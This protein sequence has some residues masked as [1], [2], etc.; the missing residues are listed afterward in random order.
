MKREN[1]NDKQHGENGVSV[2][3]GAKSADS[4]RRRWRNG[5]MAAKGEESS[6]N[7]ASA[8]KQQWRNNIESARVSESAWRN[9]AASSG[10]SWLAAISSIGMAP[11]GGAH[12]VIRK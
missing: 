1:E 3:S 12:G 10:V 8:S 2:I 6:I 9:G 11:L 5:T 4:A 7:G